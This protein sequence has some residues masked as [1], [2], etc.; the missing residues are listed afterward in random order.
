MVSSMTETHDH[1]WVEMS[2]QEA[3]PAIHG[4]KCSVPGCNVERLGWFARADRTVSSDA[5]E[6]AGDTG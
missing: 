6:F 5:S 1:V 3:Y 4:I 2:W